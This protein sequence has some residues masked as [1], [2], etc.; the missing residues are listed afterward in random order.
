MTAR[1]RPQDIYHPWTTYMWASEEARRRGDRRAG[2]DHLLLGLLE[3]PEIEVA[4][5]VSLQEARDALDAMDREA[6]HVL[7]I[8]AS[9]D[10]PPLP[11]RDVPSRPTIKTVI[12]D[13]LRMT[14]MAKTVLQE[15]GKPMR[16]GK[17]ITPQQVLLRL[18]DL[19]EPDPAATLL[20][21]LSVN[22]DEVRLRL[23]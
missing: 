8:D 14:P 12:K 5:G 19:E 22:I 7:G 16:R 15:A 4:L 6:L 18:L 1:S 9:V 17:H 11:L 10:A 3:D 2:T 23:A 20:T 21:S 13:R